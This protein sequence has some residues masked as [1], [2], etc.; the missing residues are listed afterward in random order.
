MP[1]AV[2]LLAR[3]NTMLHRETPTAEARNVLSNALTQGN[4][5]RMMH[6][7]QRDGRWQEARARPSADWRHNGTRSGTE[8]EQE[9]NAG[10][11]ETQVGNAC[12]E[13]WLRQYSSD[14]AATLWRLGPASW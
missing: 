8:L 12:E 5:V 14:T 7:E 9:S 2:V 3:F 6:N 4:P 1:N 13:N 10:D 11:H